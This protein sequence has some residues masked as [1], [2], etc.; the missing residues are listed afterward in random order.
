MPPDP[1]G[2][3][4]SPGFVSHLCFHSIFPG[5]VLFPPMAGTED[6]DQADDHQDTGPYIAM[7]VD[8][9]VIVLDKVD[10]TDGDEYEP[11]AAPEVVSQAKEDAYRY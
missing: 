4:G 2:L 9:G 6:K 10:A 7:Q 3:V 8:F 11:G 5:I 1:V